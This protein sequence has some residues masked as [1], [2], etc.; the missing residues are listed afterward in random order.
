MNFNDDLPFFVFL[1]EKSIHGTLVFIIQCIFIKVVPYD[2]SLFISFLYLWNMTL[3]YCLICVDSLMNVRGP[4]LF[5]PTKLLVLHTSSLHLRLKNVLRVW[6]FNFRLKKRFNDLLMKD[7]LPALKLPRCHSIE[8]G[9]LSGDQG[10][11]LR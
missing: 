6:L 5:A 7:V 4:A 8:W 3:L 11:I 10:D 9:R 2:L 1:A